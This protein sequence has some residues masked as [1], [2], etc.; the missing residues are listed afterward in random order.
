MFI[1]LFPIRPAGLSPPG[2]ERRDESVVVR[3]LYGER[4]EGHGDREREVITLGSCG[5]RAPVGG[6]GLVHPNCG[7]DQPAQAVVVGAPLKADRKPPVDGSLPPP[8][9]GQGRRRWRR[10][11]P[12]L[13]LLLLLL[14]RR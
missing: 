2:Q 13:L 8:P 1:G 5:S 9:S 14:R 4:C 3:R 10:G 11:L 7:L 12:F 6:M